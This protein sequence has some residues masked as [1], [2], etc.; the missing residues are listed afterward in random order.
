[1]LEKMSG[2]F[3][4]IQ[5]ENVRRMFQVEIDK[6]TVNTDQ[7]RKV[8]DEESIDELAKTID[9]YGQLQPI[10][11]KQGDTPDTYILAAGERRLRAHKKLNKSHIYAVLTD[12]NLDEIAI[13]E[14][15]QREDLKPLEEAQ[16]YKRLMDSL[17]YTQEQVS[18]VVGK[19]RNTIT[20]VLQLNSLPQDIQD[21]CQH[22]DAPKSIMIEIAQMDNE[23]HQRA[24]WQQVRDHK[25]TVSEVRARRKSADPS[26]KAD[27][28]KPTP[29]SQVVSS[30]RSLVR[31]L[32]Q[33]PGEDIAQNKEYY[34]ELLNLRE[35]INAKIDDIE[36]IITPQNV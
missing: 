22:T 2:K 4:N 25:L 14:N 10:V 35:Q 12:G 13:I 27:R 9:K 20:Q 28:V 29:V 15:V 36:S 11:L 26:N 32:E 3:S 7:P 8:F 16:A 19:A 23:D 5:P 21:E 31:K 24:I 33:V 1:M 34:E 30:A 6:I 17:G 18:E